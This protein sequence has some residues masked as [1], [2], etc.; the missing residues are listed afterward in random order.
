MLLAQDTD[1]GN[2]EL[3]MPFQAAGLTETCRPPYDT[4]TARRVSLFANML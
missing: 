2:V 3:Y 4:N 1:A